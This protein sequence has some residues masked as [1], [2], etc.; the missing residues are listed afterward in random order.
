M[1]RRRGPMRPRAFRRLL[2]AGGLLP[3]RP[4]ERLNQAHMLEASGQHQ[5]AAQQFDQLT[6][7]AVEHG[8]LDRAGNLSLQA[9]RAYV[10]NGD[11]KNGVARVEQGLHYL[12][13]AGREYRAEHAFSAAMSALRARGMH[14]EADALQTTFPNLHIAAQQ[15]S[16]PT[17]HGQLPTKCPNCGGPIH[18]NDIDWIDDRTD[19]CPYCGSPVRAQV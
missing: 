3:P 9:G 2:H 8:M 18:P 7:M 19:E 12:V 14:L 15:E 6:A 10:E 11:A 16:E 13:Q 17:S 1:F 5:E 4:C